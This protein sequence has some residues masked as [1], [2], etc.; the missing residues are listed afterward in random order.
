MNM[1]SFIWHSGN[2]KTLWVE[3]RS[4]VQFSSVQFSR[5]VVSDSLPP[6]GL[7][8]PRPP[9]P[10]PT[11]EAYSNSCPS[12][13]W[14]HLTISSCRPLL[15]LPL[16]FPSIWVFANELALWITWPKYWSISFSISSSSEYS[17]LISFGIDWF[18]LL[19]V[20]GT[21]EYSPVTQSKASILRCMAFFIV[22]SHIHTRLLEKP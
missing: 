16:I 17:G 18:D 6:H 2:Y 3:N 9:C 11:P 13:W 22:Q 4:V 7:Q 19:A 1:N 15:L 21:Q 12:R 20:Q 5:T 10:S 14:C 8:H